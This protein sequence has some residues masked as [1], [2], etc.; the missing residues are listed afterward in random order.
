MRIASIQKEI[1]RTAKEKGWWDLPRSDGDCIALMHSELSEA[2][3]DIRNSKLR[4]Y[5]EGD[6]P[7]GLPIELADCII[8]ILDYAE[9][10]S[11]NMED[12]LYAKM[13]YNETR[14]YR[15]GGKA[16]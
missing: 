6:K 15:H 7:T 1:H 5:F 13:K 12:A 16:L 11:I 2:L 9:K 3:E 10:H 8:R 4:I 14:P